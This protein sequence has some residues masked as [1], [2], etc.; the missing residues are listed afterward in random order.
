[1]FNRKTTPK[2]RDGRVQKKNRHAPTRLNSLSIGVTRPH[3]GL[4]HVTSKQ[5]LWKFLRLIPD[6]KRVSTDLDMIYLACGR[7]GFDGCYEYPQH[8]TI[9]LSPWRNDLTIWPLDHYYLAH[10]DIFRALGVSCGINADGE[11]ECRFTEDSARAYQLL[12]IFLHELGHHHYR[13]T[14]G[15]GRSGGTEKYAEDYAIRW[16]HRLW[17]KYCDQFKFYPQGGS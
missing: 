13:I 3:A 7:G 6:W 4:R 14:Q 16:Q 5:D 12:H 2:V 17:N 15:R 11:R 8:P 1:M 10:E 9:T